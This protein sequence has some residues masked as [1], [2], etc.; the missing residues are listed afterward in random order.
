MAVYTEVSDEELGGFLAAYDIGRPLSMK[1][2]AEGVEN[3]NFLLH[4]EA[5][6]FILT[7][8]ERRTRLEDLPFFLGLMEHLSVKGLPCPQPVRTRSGDSLGWLAGRPAAMVTFL[9]GLSVRR[10][11][12]HHCALAGAALA[13]L[14]RYGA[15]FPV[16]RSNALSLDAWAPLFEGAR[17]RA[18][19][20][21][22]G[23]TALIDDELTFLHSYWPRD[24]PGGII[25][26][27]LFPDNVLFLGDSAGLIDFY[28]AC[29]DAFTYDLAICLNAWC[30]EPDGAYNV[31]KGAGMISAYQARRRLQ[32]AEIA[33]LP[34][35]GARRRAA[36]CADPSSS[37]GSTCRPARWCSP[38]IRPSTSASCAST[39]ASPVSANW[40]LPDG[41]GGGGQ[42]GDLDRRGLLGQS[43]VPAA[44]VRSSSS[45]T[46]SRRPAAVRRRPP[47]TAWSSP[48][49]SPLSDC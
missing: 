33:A 6:S 18:E 1:G 40:E 9:E 30:F 20:V 14:H 44:G 17:S 42:S 29:T 37:T 39:S 12:Q 7:L 48:P 28:F 45:A 3:S 21:A 47:T 35:P 19:S 49:R 4:A 2:I 11:A 32:P 41:G 34:D 8:Y 13:D 36:L 5:G 24:L 10:P 31:T 38:K 46:S 16:Q 15:D 22:P 23:I 26:A 25:H 27:D 43:W